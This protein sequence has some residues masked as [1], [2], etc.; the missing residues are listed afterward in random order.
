M[1]L[2]ENKFFIFDIPIKINLKRLLK[3]CLYPIIS[4][5]NK[6]VVKIFLRKKE[7]KKKYK[8]T[9]CAIFR[10][11]CEILKEWIEYH[12][13][14]GVEHFILYNN[15][16]RDDF[17]S[18]LNPYIKSGIVT[19]I[20]WPKEHS[21]MEAYADCVKK[22][23][24]ETEWIG[25]IDLDEFV[26]PNGKYITIYDFLKKF[27]YKAPFVIVYWRIF[28]S[29]GYIDRDRTKLVSESFTSCSYKFL[30][31]GKYFYNTKFEYD[32]PKKNQ[33]GFMHYRW[34][35]LRNIS[36]PPMNVFG[37]FCFYDIHKVCGYC[38]P[39]Q[40]NHYVIKSYNEYIEK[41]A[42]RGGG[43]HSIQQGFHDTQYFF[44]HDIMCQD[45]DYKIYRYLSKL[46]LYLK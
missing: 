16:S 21:Q 30:N 20:D 4:I 46:K 22:F 27:T 38:F 8:L 5:K 23:R 37:K 28:G 6:I 33:D 40:I 34:G 41:K 13:L 15:L 19:L 45:K 1:L 10:D 17:A 18:I 7:E 26:V 32:A 3:I 31:I 29:S 43:I 36:I 25:F 35:S 2:K 14:V 11:E 9:L 42:K 12:K 24:K 39:I 44:D